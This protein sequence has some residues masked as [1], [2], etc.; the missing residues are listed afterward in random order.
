MR[1]LFYGLILIVGISPPNIAQ[2]YVHLKV[3][4]NNYIAELTKEC[5]INDQRCYTKTKGKALALC[6][7]EWHKRVDLEHRRMFRNTRRLKSPYRRGF[8]LRQFKK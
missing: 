4:C 2:A 8:S 6:Y 5:L 1:K 3:I 7:R